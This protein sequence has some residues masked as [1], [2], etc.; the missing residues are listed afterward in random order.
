MKRVA[1]LTSITALVILSTLAV[2]ST[3]SPLHAAGST[4]EAAQVG[5]QTTA[6]PDVTRLVTA[7]LVPPAQ[8]VSPCLWDFQPGKQTLTD[9]KGLVLS[10]YG[11]AAQAVAAPE[12]V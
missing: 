8:C 3:R 11:T 4:G 12:Q 1:T 9:F 7:L 2:L 6:S 10:A 5:L